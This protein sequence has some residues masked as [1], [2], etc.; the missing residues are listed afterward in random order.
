MRPEK[1][2][3]LRLFSFKC[4]PG[5]DLATASAA[6][7]APKV[8]AALDNTSVANPVWKGNLLGFPVRLFTGGRGG[9]A[10]SFRLLDPKT[11]APVKG[12]ARGET[13][14]GYEIEKDEFL[15]FTDAE[16][17]ACKPAASG[18]L[19]ELGT[20]SWA[21]FNPVYIEASYYL[22]PAELA[23]EGAYA[24]LFVTLRRRGL[25]LLTRITLS[26]RERYALV[27]PGTTGL[28]LL[29]LLFEAEANHLAEFRTITEGAKV[30][31]LDAPSDFHPADFVDRQQVALMALI[32]RKTKSKAA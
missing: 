19:P 9:P 8:G 32:Q 14:R 13:I 16:I 1:P 20:I 12:A 25:A 22:A 6:E 17:D 21:D 3:H 18:E 29:T 10:V 5:D 28:I 27:R 31:R 15:A 2:T 7:N 11:N 26:G 23:A 4:K 24:N 30:R